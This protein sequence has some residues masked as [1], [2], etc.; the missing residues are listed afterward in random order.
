MWRPQGSSRLPSA[1][2]T[3][4]PGGTAASRGGHN[5]TASHSFD[6]YFG[7]LTAWGRKAKDYYGHLGKK[8]HAIGAVEHH[9]AGK[10]I[11]PALKFLRRAGYRPHAVKARPGRGKGSHGGEWI[12][13]RAD[14]QSHDLLSKKGPKKVLQGRG[15]A[16]SVVRFSGIVFANG[17]VYLEPSVGPKADV[18]WNRLQEVTGALKALGLPTMLTGDWNTLRRRLKPR[19]SRRAGMVASSHLTSRSRAGRGRDRSS[20]TWSP[21]SP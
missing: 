14:I 6:T 13:T 3:A 19:A 20:T 17:V 9:L 2:T 4:T 11:D 8:F 7:N 16:I 1:A 18:N 5:R 10:S 15:W 21:P 12:A